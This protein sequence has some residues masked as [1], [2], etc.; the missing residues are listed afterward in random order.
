MGAGLL[1]G[2]GTVVTDSDKG[3]VLSTSG[4]GALT[5]PGDTL[6]GL[7]EGFSL[8]FWVKTDGSSS[9]FEAEGE[10]FSTV[11][12]SDLRATVQANG[13]TIRTGEASQALPAGRMGLR[14]LQRGAHRHGRVSQRPNWFP[15]RKRIF[16]LSL[17]T[18]GL[19][20][21]A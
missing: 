11:I 17:E 1:T 20:I 6:S 10:G 21:S 2:D 8:C 15:L 13:Q 7:T 9:L 14:H 18:A 3:L 4:A 12:G 16:L 5:L 19:T